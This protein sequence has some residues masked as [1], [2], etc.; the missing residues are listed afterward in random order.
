MEDP[1]LSSYTNLR[2]DVWCDSKYNANCILRFLDV[3]QICV[4]RKLHLLTFRVRQFHSQAHV[5]RAMLI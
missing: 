5:N 1:H 3:L 2:S 4:L